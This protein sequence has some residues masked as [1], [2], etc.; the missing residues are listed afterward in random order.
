[1]PWLSAFSSFDYP[2]LLGEN[3]P[4]WWGSLAAR[5]LIQRAFTVVRH[6]C[7][8]TVVA[9]LG[10]CLLA[11]G[12]GCSSMHD[13]QTVDP[14][15]DPYL[16]CPGGVCGENGNPAAVGGSRPAYRESRRGNSAVGVRYVGDP[17][18]SYWGCPGGVCES[19]PEDVGTPNGEEEYLPDKVGHFFDGVYDGVSGGVCGA[20]HCLHRAAQPD[21]SGDN[22]D[23]HYPRFHP[24]PVRPVF[25]PRLS[26]GMPAEIAPMPE[27]TAPEK[28]RSVPGGPKASD[29][30]P[31]TLPSTP[32]QSKSDSGGWVPKQSPKPSPKTEPVAP[33]IE[34]EEPS[35]PPKPIPKPKNDARA[36]AEASWIF[37]TSLF[38]A[39]SSDGDL[40][41][42]PTG[43]TMSR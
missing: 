19:R 15:S 32:N 2:S 3:P 30:P 16:G 37:Q 26:N 13:A 24:V 29:V 1:M 11:S 33:P 22:W 17:R 8:M 7:R 10:V 9:M 23:D 36:S 38:S 14:A 12:L 31:N 25:S 6:S 34:N 4:A 21:R 41:A 18:D 39:K 20:F 27:P 42:A 43:R 35:P 28:V 40:Q 5:T